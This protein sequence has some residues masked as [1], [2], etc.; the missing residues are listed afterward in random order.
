MDRPNSHIRTTVTLSTSSSRCDACNGNAD[1]DDY[2]HI[3]GGLKGPSDPD[4]WLSKNNGCGAVFYR[5][6]NPY[7]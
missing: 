7:V 1:P 6:I 3:R 5:R 2:A 4:S